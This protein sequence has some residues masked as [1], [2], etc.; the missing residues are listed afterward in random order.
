M[1]NFNI[2]F[3]RKTLKIV[4]L[5]DY[6]F[7]VEPRYFFYGW[8]NLKSC[9]ARLSVVKTLL[10][11]KK[12]LPKGY[13]FKIWDCF[14]KKETQKFIRRSFRKRL[15]NLHPNWNPKKILEALNIFTG[16]P[17]KKI[18]KFRLTGH[19]FGGAVDLTIVNE[20]GEELDMG[21][22]F[23]DITEKAA[24]NYYENKKSLNRREKNI[25]KNRRLL[26]KVIKK[27]S[28]KSYPAEWW[29]WSYNR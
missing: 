20:R 25:R 2:K 7:L 1:K 28:F 23:D 16:S 17:I 13:N 8:S 14:R 15:E 11:A 18:K 29:H 26:T 19:F 12:Y 5:R 3:K 27:A 9:Y 4:D 10:L 24:L 21:T 22:D 6:G